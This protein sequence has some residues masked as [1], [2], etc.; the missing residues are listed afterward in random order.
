MKNSVWTSF[1]SSFAALCCAGT[2]VLL[3]FLTGAG[4]GFLINDFIL[5]PLLFISL[6]FMFY[7]I[8]CNKKQHLSTKPLYVSIVGTTTILVGIFVKPIIWLG[9]I[10]LFVATIWDFLLVIKCKSCEVKK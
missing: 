8:T 1:T 7:S 3:A 5:F 9:I 2:P 6:G 10:C 4:L